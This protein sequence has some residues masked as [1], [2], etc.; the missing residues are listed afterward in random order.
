[1]DV[2]AVET[3]IE[4][5]ELAS[6]AARARSGNSGAFEELAARVRGRVARWAGRVVRDPDDADD[7]AQLVLMRVAT[8]L[9]SFDGRSRFTTWLYRVTRSV[10]LNRVRTEQRRRSI[11]DRTAA[12]EPVVS[13]DTDAEQDV[14]RL[15]E[16]VR[17]YYGELTPRQREVFSMADFQ[18]LSAVEI[19]KS[20]EIDSS[21]VRVLLLQ[22]RRIIRRRMLQD[23]AALLEGEGFKT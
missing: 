2:H 17:A 1:M 21:T 20:L 4:D 15:V 7:V 12:D 3:V 22:A 9:S 13:I 14:G 5:D 23:H 8:R 11:L 16:I 6:L 10:A 18:G 19:A